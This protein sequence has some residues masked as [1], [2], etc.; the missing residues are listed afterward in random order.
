MNNYFYQLGQVFLSEQCSDDALNAVGCGPVEDKVQEEPQSEEYDEGGEEEEP[1]DTDC[2]DAEEPEVIYTKGFQKPTTKPMG[3]M[4]VV[5]GVHPPGE[6][7]GRKRTSF[8]WLAGLMAAKQQ[9]IDFE[10]SH[11]RVTANCRPG[12]SQEK[13][14]NLKGR[15]SKFYRSPQPKKN[16]NLP[17]IPEVNLTVFSVEVHTGP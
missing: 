10:K 9:R 14:E 15:Q 1:R 8:D 13:E 12:G 7:G 16:V 11:L 3:S 2:D 5:N 4:G 17:F 6:L